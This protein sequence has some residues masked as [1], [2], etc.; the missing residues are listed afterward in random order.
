MSSEHHKEVLQ[1][2]RFRPESA[3]DHFEID[4]SKGS[5]AHFVLTKMVGRVVSEYFSALKETAESGGF[6]IDLKLSQKFW[7]FSNF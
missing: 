6:Q 7:K 2:N 4:R 3:L 5:S 1:K